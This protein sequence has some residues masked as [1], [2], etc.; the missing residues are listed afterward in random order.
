MWIFPCSSYYPSLHLHNFSHYSRSRQQKSFSS[1]RGKKR[2]SLAKCLHKVLRCET[3]WRSG[4][5]YHYCCRF[6]GWRWNL[7]SVLL[8]LFFAE[9]L[10]ALITFLILWLTTVC[11][12]LCLVDRLKC[13]RGNLNILYWGNLSEKVLRIFIWKRVAGLSGSSCKKKG[14][15]NLRFDI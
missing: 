8:L 3:S 10:A 2:I 15:K 12:R 7:Y 4:K 11:S 1:K 14:I 9:V 5:N 13:R 6:V